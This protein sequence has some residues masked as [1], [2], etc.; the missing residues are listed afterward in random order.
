M[1]MHTC[2]DTKE[3]EKMGILVCQRSEVDIQPIPRSC[4][5]PRVP[6]SNIR[7]G[8]VR[9][10]IGAKHC[11]QLNGNGCTKNFGCRRHLTAIKFIHYW[12]QQLILRKIPL[13]PNSGIA[14][15]VVHWFREDW[16]G[17]PL[18]DLQRGCQ[19]YEVLATCINIHRYTRYK[20][21]PVE[22]D[23]RP[24]KQKDT[25]RWIQPCEILVFHVF[26]LTIPSCLYVIYIYI[27][28]YLYICHYLPIYL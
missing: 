28:I 3:F 27:Y 21:D 5:F 25:T 4:F 15:W 16:P 8:Q 13:P 1:D 17:Q 9:H 12:D 24:N 6:I 7:Y 14:A 10:A 18:W 2:M 26:F 22:L 20:G 19:H 11:F 23:Y